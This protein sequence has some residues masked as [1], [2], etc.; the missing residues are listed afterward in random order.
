MR[1][2]DQV[3]SLLRHSKY[4]Q[5]PL[6]CFVAACYILAA[7]C[8][9]VLTLVFRSNE[10]FAESQESMY[11]LSKNELI[12]GLLYLPAAVLG[13]LYLVQIRSLFMAF[14][15]PFSQESVA[16]LTENHSGGVCYQG[17]ALQLDSATQ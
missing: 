2:A 10:V 15:D 13:T 7:I 4:C 11:L 5:I 14:E 8:V 9:F 16:L 3:Y 17:T 6:S 12:D 1:S